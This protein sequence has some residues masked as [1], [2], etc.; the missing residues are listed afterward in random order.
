MP[1]C[2]IAVG[3]SSVGS[4]V[5]SLH[6]FPHPACKMSTGWKGPTVFFPLLQAFQAQLFCNYLMAA[7]QIPL[8]RRGLTCTSYAPY[9]NIIHSHAQ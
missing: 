4:E 1:R 6:K 2:C 3:C 5:Y 7:N 8:H 9:S